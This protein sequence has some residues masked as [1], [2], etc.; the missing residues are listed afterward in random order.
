MSGVLIHPVEAQQFN[1]STV[2]FDNLSIGLKVNKPFFKKSE[3]GE[4][5]SGASGV[6]KFYGYIPLRKNW[7]IN[8][9]IPLVLVKTGETG[10]TGLGNIYVEIQKALNTGKTT[11][12]AFGLYVPTVG[13]ENY[14]KMSIGIL[15]DPYRFLQYTEGATLNTTFGYNLREKPGIIFG[16][17]IGPDIFIPTAEGG[18]LEL[19]MHYGIKGGYQFN[20]VSTWAE[21]SGVLI[22]TEEGNLDDKWMNQVFF[23]AQ[24]NR[25]I[26]RPGVFYGIHLDKFIRDEI[27][28]ILGINLQF[29]LK[30]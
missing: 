12:L 16:V 15:S 8:T 28:G 2:P 3:F 13:K 27:S 9:E 21:L 6:Y 11:W 22:V 14:E 7:Q 30:G 18:D 26:I 29:V 24:L 4:N 25:G 19:L 23:G 1:L 17:D 10:K 5:P 20:T